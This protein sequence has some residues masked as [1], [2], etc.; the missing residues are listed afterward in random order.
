MINNIKNN[1]IS[2][3]AIKKKIN[4]LNELKNV[5]TKS[6][7]LIKSQE[8]LLNLFD[9]LKTIFNNNNNNNKALSENVSENRCENISE[10]ESKNKNDGDDI[11]YEIKQ[12]NKYFKTTEPTKSLAEQIKLLK[13]REFLDDYWHMK[14]F[15]G[16]KKLNLKIF[17]VDVAYI[18]NDLDEE[19]FKKLFGHEFVALADK[20]T[21][22]I[23]KKRK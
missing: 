14:Y 5:E 4:E 20:V 16:A 1:S 3:A 18:L 9:D 7:G 11:F 22:T 6:K 10:N 23:S 8:K 21:N 12:L 15:N 2:E 19:L 17:K 13:E